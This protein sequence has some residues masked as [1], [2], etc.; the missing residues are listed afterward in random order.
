MSKYIEN[1][2]WRYATKKFDPNKK[3]SQKDLDNLLEAL[4]LSASSYGL[5]PYQVFVVEDMH[6]REKLKPVAWGQSQ[7]TESSHLIVL[8]N[9]STFGNELVDDYL[10]NVSATRGIPFKDLEGYAKF[11]KS[12]LLPLSESAKAT[13][14]ARQT[15][16]ALGNLLSAAADLKIDSCPME[17]FE[18]AEFNEI[19]GLN[20]KGLNAAVLVAIGYRSKDDSTQHNKKVRKSK[21]DLITH[22]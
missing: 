11:M 15:Y 10:E 18:S 3:V 12:K 17:G 5:Q 8:A 14:T 7:I 9:Q 19:L 21:S 22:I 13:W 20:E 6:I 2:N 1:L 4:S 16:I